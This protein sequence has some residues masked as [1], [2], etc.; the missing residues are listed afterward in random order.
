M[1]DLVT[2]QTAPVIRQIEDL[3]AEIPGWSPVDQLFALFNLVYATAGLAG[4]VIEL[5]SWCGRSS[6]VLALAASCTGNTTVYCVDLFPEKDDWYRNADG[7]YSFTVTLGGRTFKAYQE[8]RVWAE[9][10]DRDIAPLYER[11]G[12]VFEIFQAAI[13]RNGFER[14]VV[15][16]RGTLATFA[17]TAPS[18][19]KCR[20]AFVDGDHSYAAVCEDIDRIE[21]YLVPGGWICFDD[22]FS[23]Y[24]GV[25]RAIRDRILG[26]P[27]YEL[28]QQMTRKLFVAR[29][30]ASS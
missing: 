24:E 1:T 11:H 7:S 23:Y 14:I 22:A 16:H 5:G 4:D 2:S 27:G 21:R 17:E 26:N 9:P 20:V 6:A 30:R 10:F 15:P 3:V 18:G 19:L 12:G 29:R 25:N 13:A 8:Q 28:A